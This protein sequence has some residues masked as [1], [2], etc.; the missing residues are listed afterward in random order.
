M[1]SIKHKIVSR[2]I[3]FF[4]ITTMVGSGVLSYFFVRQNEPIILSLKNDAQNK[5]SLIK[6]VWNSTLKKESRADIAILL[7]ALTTKENTDI[8]SI[9]KRYLTDF[10]NLS[11]SSSIQAIIEAV[12][13]E[14]KKNGDY[15][16]NLY[17]EQVSI[18]NKISEIEANNKAYSEIA[19][20][21]QMCSLVLIIIRKD[22][23]KD[24]A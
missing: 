5:Q 24:I 4:A 7:S 22:M 19:F 15:I 9:K 20:L 17:L 11:D 18:Q 10:S 6:D 13:L 14:S 1:I 21:L 3:L 12:E 8:K 16:D 2:L 23:P